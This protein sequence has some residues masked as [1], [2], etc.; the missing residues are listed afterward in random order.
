MFASDGMNS[1]ISLVYSANS[2]GGVNRT[3]RLGDLLFAI[4]AK[5]MPCGETVAK[6]H[7]RDQHVRVFPA[8]K[9][10][11]NRHGSWKGHDRKSAE[12]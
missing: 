3:T 9:H 12:F 2:G 5:L 11:Q 1:P 7:P 8:I 10:I 6:M 4:C